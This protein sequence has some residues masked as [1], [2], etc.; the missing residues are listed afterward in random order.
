[1][2]FLH[3]FCGRLLAFEID[4]FFLNAEVFLLIMEYTARIADVVVI[5]V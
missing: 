4:T 2:C 5:G 3:T 1:M